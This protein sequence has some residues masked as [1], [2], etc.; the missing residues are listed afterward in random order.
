MSSEA[1]T[2]GSN[3]T[4]FDGGKI[5]SQVDGGS[6]AGDSSLSVPSAQGTQSN[7]NFN[8]AA[9]DHTQGT[10][11]GFHTAHSAVSGSSRSKPLTVEDYRRQHPGEFHLSERLLSFLDIR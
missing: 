3:N 2:K 6:R 11:L 9:N 5:L 8:Q 4:A 7:S 10:R 1:G